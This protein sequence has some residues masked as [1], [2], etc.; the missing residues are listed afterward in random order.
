MVSIVP[1]PEYRSFA[2]R[3]RAASLARYS[4]SCPPV[5]SADS[6]LCVS[7]WM[8]ILWPGTL[9]ITVLGLAVAWP[10][11]PPIGVAVTCTKMSEADMFKRSSGCWRTGAIRQSAYSK[12][13]YR[14]S[15]ACRAGS[16]GPSLQRR[17]AFSNF[18]YC[19]GP[20]GS[21]ARMPKARW[22][23]DVTISL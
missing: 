23:P 14:L 17:F 9:T 13:G 12:A 20:C 15:S 8:S 11:L 5:A 7:R 10:E 6:S 4:A 2:K 21:R 1:I 19:T 22:G 3:F 16:T 18:D